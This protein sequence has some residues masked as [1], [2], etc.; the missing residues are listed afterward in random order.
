MPS[1]HPIFSAI[2]GAFL[3][4]LFPIFSVPETPS[5][6]HEGWNRGFATTS[7]GHR[8]L[9]CSPDWNR[10]GSSSTSIQVIT[11]DMKHEKNEKFAARSSERGRIFDPTTVT[12]C[13]RR[14]VSRRPPLVYSSIDTVSN[15][16]AETRKDK[17]IGESSTRCFIHQAK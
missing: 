5:S 4:T 3:P 12:L 13:S 11:G 9:D 17:G 16:S 7:S 2:S 10:R 6:N 8:N 14:N 15:K 1:E